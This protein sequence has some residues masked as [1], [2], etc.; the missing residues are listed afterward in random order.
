M[1]TNTAVFGIYRDAATLKGGLDALREAGFRSTDVSVLMP[2]NTGTKEFVPKRAALA[3]G[4]SVGAPTRAS[5]SDAAG[6]L[7][8]MEALALPGMGIFV[9]AGPILGLL[10]GAGGLAGALA[11]L[12]IPEQEAKHYQSRVK[13]GGILA[14]V[15]CDNADW[16]EKAE[17]IL[18]RTGVE[19]IGSAGESTADYAMGDR[20]GTRI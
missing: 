2:E 6:W 13:N 7:T 18:R 5:S 20:R 11:G 16:A 3:A 19:E 12:G 14:S 15:N 8:G 10:A 1:R 4:S 9:A 17:G